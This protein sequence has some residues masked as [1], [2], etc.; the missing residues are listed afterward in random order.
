MEPTQGNTQEEQ[1]VQLV[2]DHT[3]IAKLAHYC[4]DSRQLVEWKLGRLEAR[5]SK[6]QETQLSRLMK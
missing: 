3:F 5:F 6:E 2:T 1:M 4:S